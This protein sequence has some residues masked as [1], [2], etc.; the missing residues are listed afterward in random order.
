M[1]DGG[2]PENVPGTILPGNFNSPG[3]AISP[4]GN[5]L[6]FLAVSADQ[7]NPVSKIALVPLDAGPKPPVQILNPDPRI[8]SSAIFTPDGKAIVYA[9]RENGV[10]NLWRQALDGSKGRQISNF[11]SDTILIS[12]FSPDGKTLGVQRQHVESDV[13]LLRDAGTSPD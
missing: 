7:A 8:A 5:L 12:L 4:D 13:V 2:T 1:M 3:L 6:S 11:N 9:I 10:D